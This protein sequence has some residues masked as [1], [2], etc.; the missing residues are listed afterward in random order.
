MHVKIFYKVIDLYLQDKLVKLQE[1]IQATA[2]VKI[3]YRAVDVG[4][5]A[6]VDAAVASS[7]EEI[8]QVDILIN[9]VSNFQDKSKET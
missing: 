7:I 4:N 2:G 6:D 8:G 9:N 5:Y 3:A 1:K